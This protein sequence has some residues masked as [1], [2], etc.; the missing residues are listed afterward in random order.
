M[1][2]NNLSS[3]CFSSSRCQRRS[4]ERPPGVFR[5]THCSRKPWEGISLPSWPARYAVNHSVC[6]SCIPSAFYFCFVYWL[7]ARVGTSFSMGILLCSPPLSTGLCRS[8]F[9][10]SSLA[11]CKL[12]FGTELLVEK[13]W[14]W[15][16]FYLYCA[17]SR[18]GIDCFD[19]LEL[20]L[21][22]WHACSSVLCTHVALCAGTCSPW[23]ALLERG[24]QTQLLPSPPF[25]ALLSICFYFPSASFSP[26]L[27]ALLEESLLPEMP[28][29]SVTCSMVKLVPR[30]DPS[31]TAPRIPAPR[32]Q[33]C[34]SWRSPVCSWVC[35]VPKR[36][37]QVGTS[38]WPNTGAAVLILD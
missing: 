31:P 20:L 22:V 17:C 34:W 21:F 24:A 15:G 16:K 19:C 8:L 10:P 6:F 26:L 29:A 35:D 36:T 33:S 25:V 9:A 11:L 7:S 30:G 12:G 27:W 14:N 28:L 37:V 13:N 4:W 3:I 32:H 38:L 2:W 18:M 23:G 1:N 5:E